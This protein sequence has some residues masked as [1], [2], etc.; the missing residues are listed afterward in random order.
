MGDEME[1]EEMGYHEEVGVFLDGALASPDIPGDIKEL[2]ELFKFRHLPTESLQ[3]FSAQFADLAVGLAWTTTGMMR[4]EALRK[5]WEA[6]NAA[7]VGRIKDSGESLGEPRIL[8]DMVV[9]I[10][11]STYPVEE[12][13][14]DLERDFEDLVIDPR[15][16]GIAEALERAAEVVA[17]GE[18]GPLKEIGPGAQITGVD[19]GTPEGSSTVE[20]APPVTT[21]LDPS[22]LPEGEREQMSEAFAMMREH[23]ASKMPIRMSSE[24]A[25]KAIV[26]MQAK[27]S[28]K[29]PE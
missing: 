5:L 21:S 4:L 9:T 19:W 26:E 17:R 22:E 27:A 6:K 7:I 29:S 23:H 3:R 12:L 18:Q 1:D 10:G 20:L 2:L 28:G 16:R 25:S 11:A 13:Q 24:E 8:R 15:A 14:V